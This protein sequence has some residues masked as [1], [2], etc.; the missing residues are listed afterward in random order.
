MCDEM[1]L[2]KVAMHFSHGPEV[3]SPVFLMILRYLLHS[4]TCQQGHKIE[5]AV[6]DL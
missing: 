5:N 6:A 3:A 4:I 1:L 2:D